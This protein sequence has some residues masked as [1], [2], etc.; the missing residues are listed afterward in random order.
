MS[1]S[2]PWKWCF[3]SVL[4]LRPFQLDNE[5][6]KSSASDDTDGLRDGGGAGNP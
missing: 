3:G 6:Y 1:D 4:S 5:D 2:A